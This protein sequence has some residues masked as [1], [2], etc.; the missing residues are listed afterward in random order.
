M[1][2]IILLLIVLLDFSVI[3]EIV[4]TQRTGIKK[5]FYIL[6]VILLPV[7]GVTVY[8]AVR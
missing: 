3:W 5:T 1:G 8:Y 7:I 6:M 2:L 4:H